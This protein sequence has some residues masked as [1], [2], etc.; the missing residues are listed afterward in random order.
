[1]SQDEV[2][3]IVK[4]KSNSDKMIKQMSWEQTREICF[5]TVVAMQGTKIFKKPEDLFKFSWEK[6]ISEAKKEIKRLTKEELDEKIRIIKEK[7][8]K[9][10]KSV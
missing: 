3:A 4:T 10:K 5:W 1:M 8:I 2:A 7:R 6:K 9:I